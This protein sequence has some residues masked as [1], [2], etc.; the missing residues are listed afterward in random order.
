M[1][2]LDQWADDN[3]KTREPEKQRD[4]RNDKEAIEDGMKQTW[5]KKRKQWWS[6]WDYEEAEKSD[7]EKNNKFTKC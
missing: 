6:E 4:V 1:V 5:G 2:R 3:E 7:E